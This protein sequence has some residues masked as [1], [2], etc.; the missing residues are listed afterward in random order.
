MRLAKEW[1]KI[2]GKNER[3]KNTHIIDEQLFQDFNKTEK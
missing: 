3:K 1:S 2:E